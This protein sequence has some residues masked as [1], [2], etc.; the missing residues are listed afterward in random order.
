MSLLIGIFTF[1]LIIVSIVLILVVLMQKS[2]SDGAVAAMGGGIAESTFGAETGN[3][4][5]SIT[6]YASIL[7]F[8]LSFLLYLAHIHQLKVAKN[9]ETSLPTVSVPAAPA[10]APAPVTAP[11]TGQASKTAPGEKAKP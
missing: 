8:V 2:K 10:P 4:L 6:K 11:A 3:V 9:V 5:V 7:F 1:L